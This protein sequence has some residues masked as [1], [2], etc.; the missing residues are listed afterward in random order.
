[1]Q[2]KL[3]ADMANIKAAV[4]TSFCRLW[5][6]LVPQI[7]VI[8]PMS[9]LCWVCQQHCRA[10][11]RS[12]NTCEEEKSQEASLQK[13]ACFH[14]QVLKDAEAHPFL[15]TQERSHYRTVVEQSK[16]TLQNTFTVDGQLEVPPI[17]ACL[18]PAT[19]DITMHFS[20]DM[21]QQVAI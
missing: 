18:P 4:Y 9:D 17:C 11:M 12:A 7:M 13:M 16:K 15:A 5:R 2:Y 10:I 8:K 6:Q 3:S 21:A 1:M 14:Q 19:K 20:F